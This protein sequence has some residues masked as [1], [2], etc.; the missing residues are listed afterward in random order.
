MPSRP[1]LLPK[2]LPRLLPLLLVLWG[3]GA[4]GGGDVDDRSAGGPGPLGEPTLFTT[5]DGLLTFTLPE[6]WGDEVSI[7]EST[8][9]EM[10][11]SPPAPERVFQ[12]I[13]T[14]RDSR[15][16]AENLFNLYVYDRGVW[17]GAAAQAA[18]IGE[19]VS[20]QG[21]VV[22]VVGRP[23][24]NPFPTGSVDHGR[25]ERFSMSLDEIR[26]ALPTG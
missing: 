13:L 20:R 4:C 9:A 18:D 23:P 14:P 5:D 1:L 3:A 22:Y 25:F 17:E 24:E 15:F 16:A 26:E 6:R 10:E 2:P 19:E 21:E 12:F 8:P 7:R 11:W